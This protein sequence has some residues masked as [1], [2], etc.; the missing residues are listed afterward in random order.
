[1]PRISAH[2]GSWLEN[3]TVEFQG[4]LVRAPWGDD[5]SMGRKSGQSE[6]YDLPDLYFFQNK[7]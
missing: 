6:L 7:S 1:M 3:D 5:K 2:N 4:I